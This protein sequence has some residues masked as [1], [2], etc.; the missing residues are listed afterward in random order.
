MTE[1]SMLE[2]WDPWDEFNRI[3]READRM[4]D[5]YLGRLSPDRQVHFVPPMDMGLSGDGMIVRLALPGVLEE[6]I[7]IS[8]APGRIV[9]R[10]ERQAAPEA[11]PTKWE[12]REIRYG[13]FFREVPLPSGVDPEAIRAAYSEGLL[14]LRIPGGGS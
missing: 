6:D 10:G 1:A 7:D 5:E 13:Y 8:F 11:A 12:T 9:I 14:T 2:A 4:F 3:W